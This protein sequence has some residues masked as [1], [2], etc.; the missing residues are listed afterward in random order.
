MARSN[1]NH[2]KLINRWPVIMEETPAHY[3][4]I[5][6][7]GVPLTAPCDAVY[8][9]YERDSIADALNEAGELFAQ[10][11]GFYPRPTFIQE[12]VYLSQ[13]EAYVWQDLRLQYGYIESFGIRT[14]SLIQAG[15]AVAY[16]DPD[17]DGFNELATITVVTAVSNDEIELYFQV[18]DGAESAGHEFWQIEPFTTISASAGTVTITAPSWLFVKPSIWAQPYESPNYT[19][20]NAANAN[21]AGSFITNVDVYRVYADD[22]AAVQITGDPILCQCTDL[23]TPVTANGQGLIID[24]KLGIVRVRLTCDTCLNAW[25]ESVYISYKAGYPLVN[26]AMARRLETNM[27]RMAN[28]LLPYQP[29][30]FCDRT[31]NIWQRDT[32]EIRPEF[33]TQ[34]DQHPFGGTKR[35]RI[36]AWQNIKHMQLGMATKVTMR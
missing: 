12:R 1:V 3:N 8:T 18:A 24:S 21:S 11:L 28:T 15:V 34:F 26:R 30:S 10:H 4:Q 20:R 25:P 27:I 19:V 5:A 2:F 9:Q 36:E 17:G 29:E 7:T 14:T 35:G 32:E 31:F 13:K 23:D 6:G 22:T 16:T 33:L